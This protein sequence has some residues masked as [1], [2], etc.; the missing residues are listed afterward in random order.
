MPKEIK[1]LGSELANQIAAGEVVEN[2]AAVVK[3]LVENSI[4]SGARNIQIDLEEGGRSL[5]KIQDDG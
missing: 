4:D 3:E 5:I 2:P 1:I